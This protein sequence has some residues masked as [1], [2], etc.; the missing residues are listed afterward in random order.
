[1]IS[2]C[3]DGRFGINIAF[4]NYVLLAILYHRKKRHVSRWIWDINGVRN[5]LAPHVQLSLS[6]YPSQILIH[7]GN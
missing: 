2:R 5:I 4:Q 1:V 3:A 7:G 6:R